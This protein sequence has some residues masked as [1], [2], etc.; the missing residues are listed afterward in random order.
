MKYREY[1]NSILEDKK[2]SIFTFEKDN[3]LHYVYRIT[4]IETNE[5]YYGSRTSDA[6]DPIID[7][8]NYCSSSKRK[9]IIK[10]NKDKFKF[11]IIRTFTNKDD[12][13][14]FESFLHYKFN[15]KLKNNG[16]F[17]EA[18]QTPFGFNTTGIKH[19][20]TVKEKIREKHLNMSS[21][22]REKMTN[23]MLNT[24]KENNS[25]ITMV[26][27]TRKTLDDNGLNAFQRGGIKSRK[28]MREDID[29]N[30][31]NAFQ[32]AGKVLSKTLDKKAKRYN[33]YDK[34]DKLVHKCI[35]AKDV[36]KISQKLPFMDKE[37]YL[38]KDKSSRT[39]YINNNKEYLIGYYVKEIK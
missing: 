3:R 2:A 5:H 4:E 14:I 20:H 32:R 11:K 16:F 27:K 10:E 34:N 25:Y 37:N 9:K 35:L 6:K 15:V 12:K 26:E 22:N 18:N 31:Y 33:V 19:T 39:R 36:R 23:K 30:G 38:G 13:I 24:R 7:L 29:E 21:E 28:V 1:K 17:N 8:K